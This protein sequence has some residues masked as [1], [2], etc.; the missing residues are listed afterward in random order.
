MEVT[1]KELTYAV[2]KLGDFSRNTYR[3]ETSGASTANPGQ[4]ITITLPSNTFIDAHSFRVFMN[5]ATTA[6]NSSNNTIYGKLP[7]DVSSLISNVEWHASGLSISSNF[8]EYGTACKIKKLLHTSRDRDGSIDGLLSHGQISQTNAVEQVTVCFTPPIGFMS[9]EMSTRVLN[10]SHLGDIVC[11]ITL[12]PDAVLCYKEA[13]VQMGNNFSN[14]NAR[15]AAQNI[16]YNVTSI[17]ATIDVVQ[18]SPTYERMLNDRLMSEE[19]LKIHFK[20]YYSF[21]LHGTTGGSHDVRFHLAANSVDK[22]YAV[23]RDNNYSS[24]GIK[25]RNY[26]GAYLNDSKCANF[27]HFKAY[28]GPITTASGDTRYQWQVSNVSHPQHQATLVDAAATLVS[29]VD[30]HGLEGRGNM[31]SSLADYYDGKCVI[32]LILNFPGPTNVSSG[33]NS[34]GASVSFNLKMSGQTIDAA[35][36]AS[37]ISGSIST[38]VLAECTSTLLIAAGRSLSVSD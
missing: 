21:S 17:H 33:F 32:P 20:N 23:F 7:A 6:D 9:K 16:T 4:V 34:K 30:T 15:A 13:N 24:K 35:N 10:T 19:S 27:Y 11:R 22:C 2:A 38:Y 26:S 36:A 8:S 31:I 25:A 18:F 37:Q 3:L 14:A 12:A 29:C 1:P 5:I 28:N